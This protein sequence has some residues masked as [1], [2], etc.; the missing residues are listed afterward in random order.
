MK[1]WYRGKYIP[2]R[3][4]DPDSPI[5]VL[6][7]GHYEQPFLAKILKQIGKF[8]LRHRQWILGSLIAITGI[9]ITILM[10]AK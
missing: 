8:W 9:L 6:S 3:E 5:Y 4:N 10:A 1:N 7:P 2:P